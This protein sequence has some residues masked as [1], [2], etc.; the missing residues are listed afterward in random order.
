MPAASPSQVITR[1]DVLRGLGLSVLAVG[2]VG[3][4]DA[5]GDDPGPDQPPGAGD[6]T[7]ASSDVERSAPDPAAVAAGVAS[8]QALGAGLW[9]QL[10]AADGNLAISP[11]SVAVALGMTVNGAKGTTLDEM[12]TVLD[13]DSVETANAGYN[14]VAQHVES[15]AGPLKRSKDDDAEIALDTANSLF[16]QQGV[17]WEPAFLDALAASYGAGVQQ[18]D[19]V[20]ATEA[21]RRAI[22]GWTAEQ[23]RDKIPEL[24]PPDVLSA[25]TRLVLVNALYLK[26]PWE[27]P[28][29]KTL[30][31]DGDFHLADGSAVSVPMMRSSD[32]VGGSAGD[33]WR[34]AR[35]PYAGGM[36]AMTVVLPDGD[37]DAVVSGGAIADVLATAP[38]QS[39]ALTMPRWTFRSPSPLG[40]AL[41]AMGMPTAFSDAADLTGMSTELDLF[42]AAVLHEVFIAVDEEGTEAA[43]ATAVVVDETSAPIVDDELVLD[44]PFLFVIHDVEHGTPLFVGRV[45]DPS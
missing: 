10:S 4:L 7:L 13:V 33:G 35:V 9:G 34:A 16:G 38:S 2:A 5:C 21:A 6:L 19:F 41:I 44:R 31:Q 23:T 39:V 17:T 27:R 29:E 24:I 1:R 18:V 26:A 30:T 37:I 43:A 22:N 45:G 3:L 11:F 12:L 42:I 8:M 25:L 15:L 36:L 28:F 20:S 32:P 40:D 14:S